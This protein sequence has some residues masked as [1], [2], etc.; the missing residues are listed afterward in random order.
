MRIKH[1]LVDLI[2]NVIAAVNAFSGGIRGVI[3]V[4]IVLLL[5]YASNVEDDYPEPVTTVDRLEAYR[6]F[7]DVCEAEFSP[8]TCAYFWHHENYGE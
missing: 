8:E 4:V 5:L 7:W 3:V 1:D 2:L 6:E